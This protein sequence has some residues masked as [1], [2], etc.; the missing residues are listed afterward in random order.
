MT[1]LYVFGARLSGCLAGVCAVL[2][3]L[4]MP[5][6][7]RAD[8]VQECQKCCTGKGFSGTDY[9]N[10]VGWCM[11]GGGDCGAQYTCPSNVKDGKYLGCTDPGKQ[12]N[13]G[14]KLGSCGDAPLGSA[15][16]CKPPSP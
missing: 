10:C 6:S 14:D 8:Q 16:T 5:S 13:Y 2:A 7:A 9:S 11:Q 12:C 15:C 4:A 1:G 3:L